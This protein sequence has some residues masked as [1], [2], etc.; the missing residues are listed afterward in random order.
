MAG[1]R[2]R[3]VAEMESTEDAW[4]PSDYSWDGNAMRA[5]KRA[6]M[7]VAVAGAFGRGI[8]AERGAHPGLWAAADPAWREESAALAPFAII[9]PVVKLDADEH[10]APRFG[11]LPVYHSSRKL[12]GEVPMVCVVD[13]CGAS[14]AG[15]KRYFTRLRICEVHLSAQAIVVDGVVSRFCQQCGR[16]Q[17]IG[18]FTG[19]KKSCTERLDKV[20]ARHREKTMTKRPR[21][22]EPQPHWHEPPPSAWE[23]GAG[24]RDGLAAAMDLA[25]SLPLPLPHL[26]GGAASAGPALLK[27]QP[28]LQPLSA[29]PSTPPPL[30]PPAAVAAAVSGSSA[31]YG[32]G[33]VGGGAGQP[34]EGATSV[35][36]AFSG[37]S[38]VAP[39]AMAMASSRTSSLPHVPAAAASPP[40][41]SPP[42]GGAAA[43]G[44]DGADADTCAVR[45][46]RRL[47][48]TSGAGVVWY[49][50]R[51]W[52]PPPP[53]EA[54]P[55]A[56][57]QPPLSGMNSAVSAAATAAAPPA[58]PW[59]VVTTSI[60]VRPG[61][62]GAPLASAAP[63]PDDVRRALGA[64]HCELYQPAL[65]LRGAPSDAPPPPQQRGQAA[66]APRIR[67]VHSAASLAAIVGGGG[68]ARPVTSGYRSGSPASPATSANLGPGGGGGGPVAAAAGSG[69]AGAAAPCE[70]AA[71]ACSSGAEL[72]GS[73][74]RHSNDGGSAVH[75]AAHSGSGV[76]GSGGSGSGDAGGHGGLAVYGTGISRA[77]GGGGEVTQVAARI[78]SMLAELGPLVAHV[79]QLTR[80]SAA[81]SPTT[82]GSAP[83]L[84][85]TAGGGPA[86]GRAQQGSPEVA[87]AAAGVS[88]A[89]G[90]VG[91][92]VQ[93]RQGSAPL[94]A[95][96]ADSAVELMRRAADLASVLGGGGG[97][98]GG[99]GKGAGREVEVGLGV[100]GFGG[101]A[102]G[103]YGAP[104]SRPAPAQY[105]PAPQ[106]PQQ[107]QR[108]QQVQQ[109]QVQPQ[110]LLLQPQGGRQQQQPP[111][112]LPWQQQNQSQRLAAPQ[113]APYGNGAAHL[114]EPYGNGHAAPYAL[115][116]YGRPAAAAQAVYVRQQPAQPWPVHMQQYTSYGPAQQ[117]QQQLMM[118]A[119]QQHSYGVSRHSPLSPPMQLQQPM[120]YGPTPA[121]DRPPPHNH[122][123]N[124]Q[125]PPP[126]AN[127]DG[128]VYGN[129]YV[130]AAQQQQQ[131]PLPYGYAPDFP[132]DDN[133]EDD[134]MLLAS[135]LE[136]LSSEAD[137]LAVYLE[138]QARG[139]GVAVAVHQAVAVHR[140]CVAEVP[141]GSV[142]TA[143]AVWPAADGAAAPLP[144]NVGGGGGG[145]VAMEVERV[146]IKAMSMHPHE[147]PSNLR[148]GLGRWL[149]H[150]GA[151]AVQATLRPGCLQLV[152]DVRRPATHAGGDLASLLLPADEPEQAAADVFRFMGQRL[153]DTYVQVG[154]RVLTI[155]VGEDPRVVGWEEAAEDG[156]LGGAK[157]PELV[158]CSAAAEEG[159]EERQLEASEG[160]KKTVGE[161]EVDE[162]EEVE[163]VQ[164]VAAEDGEAAEVAAWCPPAAVRL[165]PGSL[166]LLLGRSEP[167]RRA[168]EQ[169]VLGEGDV[170]AGRALEEEEG[171]EEGEEGW[172]QQG[173]PV[174]GGN[175]E[176]AAAVGEVVEAWGRMSCALLEALCEQLE[177]QRL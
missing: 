106:H 109:H 126:Y 128:G 74:Q 168:V 94:P 82:Q 45:P 117:Q 152:V 50:T 104:P 133:G 6:H 108:Q 111:K 174:E 83:P 70:S 89:T 137:P 143:G 122:Y 8:G 41:L 64:A 53:T 156:G 91:G 18:E 79:Q 95:C 14:L 44:A 15:L 13:G 38:P 23:S 144:Y 19:K 105:Q 48:S 51:L 37:G 114:Y 134:N 118:S 28:P 141:Y 73:P 57:P 69:G 151:E 49:S 149:A 113:P 85:A 115:Q 161:A 135:L 30:A 146:S 177:R 12:E 142:A 166:S 71:D 17:F 175:G 136:D 155:R 99:G 27:L 25:A 29:G 173:G 40:A 158:G 34:M 112:E 88:A 47:V 116:S 60:V 7:N 4:A 103:S 121:Y 107:Q 93:E 10:L 125:D 87:A 3:T 61:P 75:H 110:Q 124:P 52:S 54:P 9:P 42:D 63:T 90:D 2:G 127:G 101:A 56:P 86:G 163:K 176:V 97:G 138:E 129:G 66:A 148:S 20:N 119:A 77:G 167:L 5:R 154:R 1:R 162:G 171:T 78:S 72:S 170:V 24:P 67:A 130:S 132:A 65:A 43:P 169:L 100:N 160:E 16:F 22:P 39:P 145:A 139:R 81:G 140:R 11:A 46:L 153:R 59:N 123:H 76:P 21:R 102:R 92:R 31:S 164:C 84:Q 80:G 98:A 26:G 55:T 96:V 62:D 35:C 150:G 147:L 120:H 159:V 172:S 131:Q 58:S 32:G 36:A 33:G 165:T 68:G 157:Y